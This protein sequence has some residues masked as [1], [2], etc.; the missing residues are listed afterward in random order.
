M[1]WMNRNQYLLEYDFF[2]TMSCP[3]LES[4]QSATSHVPQVSQKTIL[5]TEVI[6]FCRDVWHLTVSHLWEYNLCHKWRGMVSLQWI[7]RAYKWFFNI[8]ILSYINFPFY[9]NNSYKLIMTQ[10]IYGKHFNKNCCTH[11]F[12]RALPVANAVNGTDILTNA[13]YSVIQQ[14]LSSSG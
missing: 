7:T 1:D 9:I 5:K 14:I 6:Y 2:T 11:L 10:N 4:T 13:V 8:D 12:I 3:A